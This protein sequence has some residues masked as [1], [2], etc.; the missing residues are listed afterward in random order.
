MPQAQPRRFS[1]TELLNALKTNPPRLTK[2]WF[3]CSPII[4]SQPFPFWKWEICNPRFE[5]YNNP[6]IHLATLE[7]PTGKQVFSCNC[8]RHL[9]DCQKSAGKRVTS[10]WS[11]FATFQG[12]NSTK[13][14]HEFQWVLSQF[15]WYFPKKQ[16]WKVYNPTE[17]SEDVWRRCEDALFVFH[18]LGVYNAQSQFDL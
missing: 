14:Q 9:Y 5:P 7:S 15:P 12:T 1:V 17:D 4:N 13:V 8:F 6:L 18:L 10:S 11:N 3:I 2:V 16:I